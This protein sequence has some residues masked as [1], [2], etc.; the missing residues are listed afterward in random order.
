MDGDRRVAAPRARH[1]RG[2]LPGA[3]RHRRAVARRHASSPARSASI[4]PRISARSATA[5]RSSPTT[6]IADAFRRL[7]NG[8]QTDRYHHAE[9]GVNSRL[10]EM[11]AAVLRAA[12]A[13]AALDDAPPRARARYRAG[14]DGVDA[15]VPPSATPGTST[16]CSRALAENATR[17]RRI[18]HRARHR[19]RW[20][21][22]RCRFRDSRRWRR[23]EP[24]ECPVAAAS[25]I[26]AV[27]AALPAWKPT[28]RRSSRP[29]S[30]PSADE[31]AA[32]AKGRPLRE[33][34]HRRRR[35]H[36]LPP[37]R[38]AARARPRGLRAR[39]PVDRLDR[40]HRAPEGDARLPLHDR[41]GHQRAAAR[42]DDRPLR[43]RRS[44]SP[45]PSASS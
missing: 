38:G 30:R 29:C 37:R 44:I 35:V 13:A 27:A 39:Q 3:P 11:Q 21:T 12:A 10:D 23:E 17:C 34:D 20:C 6:T 14:L 28:H 8:G 26:G 31:I 2:L 15:H 33:A 5:A 16:I 45:P 19:E 41:L 25:A 42:R 32:V 24:A 22:I 43:R 4:R 1:R 40:Q 36:R 7:R 9:S 18:W